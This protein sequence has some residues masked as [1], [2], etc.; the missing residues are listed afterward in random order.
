MNGGQEYIVEDGL[1]SGDIIVTEGVGLLREG[2]PVKIKGGE[3][4]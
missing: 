4:K 1:A 2:M 3:S